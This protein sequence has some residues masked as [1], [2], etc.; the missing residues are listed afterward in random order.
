MQHDRDD[1]L[2]IKRYGQVFSGKMVADL[3]VSLLPGSLLIN[4]V[5]DP[6]A[7]G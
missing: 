5:I 4:S 2:K 1:N 7:G 3:L 6:M